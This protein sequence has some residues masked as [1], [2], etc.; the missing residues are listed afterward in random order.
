MKSI[1][2]F[3][4]LFFILLFFA[5]L[6]LGLK[7]SI[8]QLFGTNFS[9]IPGDF[10]DV[11]FIN[12]ILEH[13]WQW[14][15]GNT[16]GVFQAKFMFPEPDAIT[17]SD[18]VLGNLPFY[19]LFR[20]LGVSVHH[21]FQAWLLVTCCLNF[22]GGFIGFRYFLK[23][24][25][26]A[27]LATFLFTFS[28]ALMSQ[29]VHI[30]MSARYMIPL[31][32]MFLAKFF[33]TQQSKYVLYFALALAFQFYLTIYMGV[34]LMYSALFFGL[35]YYG[36]HRKTFRWSKP[37]LLKVL[38]I[39]CVFI[40]LLIPLLYPYYLRSLT[41]PYASYDE[42]STT[43]PS[44]GSYLRPFY[45][46]A[47]WPLYDFGLN[48]NPLSWLHVL[49]PGGLICLGMLL[50]PLTIFKR[51]TTL[52]L[53][54]TISLVLISVCFIKIN[55]HS[56]FYFIRKL[57]GLTAIRIVTRI[58]NIQL[59]FFVF[60]TVYS[61]KLWIGQRQPIVLAS[62]CVAFLILSFFDQ[63]NNWEAFNRTKISLS[64]RRTKWIVNQVKA[65]Y[66]SSKHKAFALLM[67]Q[68]DY[69]EFNNWQ[70]DAMLA[71]YQLNIKTVN[72][73]SSFA[74][75]V[76]YTFWNEQD[77]KGLQVWLKHNG[78]DTSQVLIVER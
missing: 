26:L 49:F 51:R 67:K 14:L 1:P 71:A 35:V 55:D 15:C 48:A 30:Q 29:Y 41:T 47:Y 19:A 3:N 36:F 7:L 33:D 40:L 70:L 63:R 28:L 77:R 76:F 72:A 32:F 62:V 12:C 60:I 25:W 9:N 39:F 45:G 11:R 74:N 44:W 8:L 46:T 34:L 4:T 66:N 2:Y 18:N 42:I 16:D 69:S 13:N 68:R 61:L 59:F 22:I 52:L 6:F 5:T 65:N 27:L 56:L 20:A 58:I 54:M 73:Y 21:S 78:L 10:C 31:C 57:P 53:L 37:L 17:Y 23:D 24:K 64:N 75:P 43:I 38:G 50:L